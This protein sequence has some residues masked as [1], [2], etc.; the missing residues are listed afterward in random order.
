[1]ESLLSLVQ[2]SVGE[3]G[4]G[5]FL[6]SMFSLPPTLLWV[7]E[8]KSLFTAGKKFGTQRFNRWWDLF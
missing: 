8:I 4:G 3:G 7:L 1:M 5:T 6:I 2:I